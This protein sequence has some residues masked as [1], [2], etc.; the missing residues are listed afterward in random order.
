MRDDADPQDRGHWDVGQV[1]PAVE[2]TR[3]DGDDH[4]EDVNPGTGLV[5]G[6]PCSAQNEMATSRLIQAATASTMAARNNP[7]PSVESQR[8]RSR[9]SISPLGRAERPHSAGIHCQQF[10]SARKSSF[11]ELQ[12]QAPPLDPQQPQKERSSA[13]RG[14]NSHGDLRGRDHDSRNDVADSE[15]RRAQ[16]EGAGQQYA[17]IRAQLQ[18]QRVRDDQA[19]EPDGPVSDVTSRDENRAGDV[20]EVVRRRRWTPREVAQSSP[21]ASRFH[22]GARIVI[23][24]QIGMT[25]AASQANVEY[26]TASSPPISQREIAKD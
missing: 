16:R 22:S 24:A 5:D 9:V 19:H 1:Q 12:P 11:T 18:S 23:N 7:P 2:E 8:A 21:T 26:S 20:A 15:K 13:E 4:S 14:D 6:A 10:G 3:G 17:M 25:A